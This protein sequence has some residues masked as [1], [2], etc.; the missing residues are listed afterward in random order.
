MAASAALVASPTAA[1]FAAGGGGG[2]SG[3]HVS[4]ASA[5][6]RAIAPAAPSHYLMLGTQDPDVVRIQAALGQNPDGIFGSRTDAAVRI[7]QARNGLASDGIVGPKTWEA[8][9]S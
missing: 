4:S 8:L 5:A 7:F 9:Y 2:G 3:S 6:N 1:A